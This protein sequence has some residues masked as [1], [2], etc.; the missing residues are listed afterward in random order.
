MSV[1]LYR[2]LSHRYKWELLEP[3]D[4]QT[5]IR[6]TSVATARW[7]VL[8]QDGMLHLEKGY[9]WDGA[10]GPAIDTSNFMEP[11]AVHDALYRLMRNLKIGWKEKPKADKLMRQLQKKNK[12]NFPRRWWTYTAVRWFAGK[13]ARG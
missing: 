12:M 8:Q 7:I 6:P 3:Y 10:S 11:S 5:K 4:I 13:R 1:F 2:K 9:Q